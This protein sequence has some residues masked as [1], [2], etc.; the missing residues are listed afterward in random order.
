MNIREGQTDDKVDY[1]SIVLFQFFFL[2][3]NFIA[4]D[5]IF[6]QPHADVSFFLVHLLSPAVH[7]NSSP[8]NTFRKI[9]EKKIKP[10]LREFKTKVFWLT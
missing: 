7:E 9:R 1:V 6:H 8:D 10:G 2:G 4:L 3:R 5:V